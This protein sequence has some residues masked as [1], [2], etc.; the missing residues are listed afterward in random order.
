MGRL[1]G[2]GQRVGLAL[3]LAL[4]LSS[5]AHGP[6]GEGVVHTL[7]RG[8]NL[9]R[10]AQYYDVSV[11]AIVKANRIR[12]VH[13]L[14]VGERLRI[15]GA[16]RSQPAY[17]LLPP[18]GASDSARRQA[19]N[20]ALRNANLS[21]SWPLRGRLTSGFGRRN[22]RLH[23]G[24]DLA[25]R[26]GTIIRAAEA[27]RVIYSGNGLGAYGNVVIVRHNGRYASVYAHNRKN[28][29]R[30]GH[31]VDKGDV[32]AELGKTG[33]AS[34]PH[35]HFEIRHDELARDPLQYLP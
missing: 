8:E 9:Y 1:A 30:K 15:P 20:D 27:G 5:C 7:R 6:E 35:L 11:A 18:A 19:R 10:I 22:G 3:V 26:P 24:I 34:G 16:R 29:V 14:R 25:A 4:A 17:A 23:E 31:I 33:N 12:D 21:F 13:A 2:P 28:H 32:I